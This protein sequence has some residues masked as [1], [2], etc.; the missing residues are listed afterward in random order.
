MKDYKR[1]LITIVTKTCMPRRA[2]MKMKRKR[3]SRRDRMEEM[4]FM[5]ATTRFLKED[6]YLCRKCHTSCKSILF[7]TQD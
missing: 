6:Q 3:R 7:L 5:R 2:K 4:A 1:S